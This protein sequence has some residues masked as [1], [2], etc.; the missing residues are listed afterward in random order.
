MAK[1][2]AVMI[3]IGNKRPSLIEYLVTNAAPIGSA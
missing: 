3:S 1:I 2:A